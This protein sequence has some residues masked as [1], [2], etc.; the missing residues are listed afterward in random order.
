MT[1]SKIFAPNMNFWDE[2]PLKPSREDYKEP[3][4]PFKPVQNKAPLGLRSFASRNLFGTP[5]DQAPRGVES[6]KDSRFY[7][8]YTRLENKG[9]V[10]YKNAVRKVQHLDNGSYFSVYQF[11]KTPGL[12][13][14]AYHGRTDY[15]FDAKKLRELLSH[16]LQSYRAVKKL[17]LPV[18]QIE[19]ITRAA[20]QGFFV[21]RKI[22][23]P[24]DP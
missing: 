18:A 21:Q 20:K 5:V 14:K 6:K 4:T 13:I 23:Y 24:I 1:S 19:N 9:T 3:L 2:Q 7:T 16:S 22:V 8:L 15:T 11:T 17:G 10:Y 12:L